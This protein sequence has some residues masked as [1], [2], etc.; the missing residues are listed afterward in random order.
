MRGLHNRI[1]A[2]FIA[3]HLF[4]PTLFAQLEWDKKTLSCTYSL[5]SVALLDIEP[6]SDNSLSFSISPA[7][8]SGESMEVS[9]DQT[10]WLNY[11]SVLESG[12]RY[13]D[14]QLDSESLPDGITLM[15]EASAYEGAGAGDL[16]VP[17]GSVTLSTNA[18]TIVSGIGNSYTGDGEG[19]GH[20]LTFS[21]VVNDVAS[22]SATSNAV[23]TI[24]YTI[25]D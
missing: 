14:A 3:F 24:T 11:S 4:A 22:L 8:E 25:R 7:T 10:L 17:A 15:V 19:N 2:L 5:P 18:Q 1:L 12:T 6:S 21:I 16:G 13:I 9:D 23:V 20:E